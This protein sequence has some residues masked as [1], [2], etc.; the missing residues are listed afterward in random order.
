M[1]PPAVLYF[2]RTSLKLVISAF[3]TPVG[4]NS[5][6]VPKI[7]SILQQRVVSSIFLSACDLW[8]L[9]AESLLVNV[10]CLPFQWPAMCLHT[11]CF[12]TALDLLDKTTRCS[13]GPHID[14]LGN[15]AACY[16]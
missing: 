3:V 2:G 8:L 12:R 7:G 9:G 15:V 16:E 11:R 13:F 1:V 6:N 10:R 5:N 4:T 14:Q